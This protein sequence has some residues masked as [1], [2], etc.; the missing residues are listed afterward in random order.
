M[1]CACWGPRPEGLGLPRAALRIRLWYVVYRGPA[2]GVTRPA[3]ATA[4][5]S[6]GPPRNLGLFSVALLPVPNSLFRGPGP[7]PV[8]EVRLVGEGQ[9]PSPFFS[10]LL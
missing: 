6:G 1:P 8:K 7:P 9:G 3:L 2:D 4:M 10:G 5:C